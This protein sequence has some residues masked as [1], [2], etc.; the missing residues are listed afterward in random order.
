MM[1]DSSVPRYGC[2]GLIVP[3]G[4]AGAPSKQPAIIHT[5]LLR[6]LSP[7]QLGAEQRQ[8]ISAHCG[9]LTAQLTGRKLICRSLWWLIEE[10]YATVQGH[11]KQYALSA[12][13]A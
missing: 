8:A 3:T 9:K 1:G 6:M 5:T 13:A 11:T 2:R 12:S 7:Q 4:L 10:S